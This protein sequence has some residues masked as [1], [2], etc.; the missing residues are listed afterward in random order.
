V[1]ALEFLILS[2][3]AAELPT[4]TFADAGVAAGVVA[5]A[6]APFQSV[7]RATRAP[8]LR[9]IAGSA[10]V[11]TEEDLERRELNDIHRVLAEVPGVYFREE[12]G[13]GLRPNIG[14]RG[15]SPDRSAKVTLLEDG[16]LL[17]PAPYSAPAAYYFPMITRMVG[18]EVFKGPAAIRFGP[19]T[20][21]GAVALSTR[22]VPTDSALRADVAVGSRNQARLHGVAALANAKWG[23]LAE[24]VWWRDSGFKSLDGG[25]DTGFERSE[26]MLKGRWTPDKPL[27]RQLEIKA[28]ASFEDSRETYL[29]L[30]DEDF[31]KQP[32]RRYSAS[33]LDRMV[34]QRYSLVAKWLAEPTAGM[35][36]S[37]NIY[38]HQFSR[39]WTRLDGF[40]EGPPLYELLSRPVQGGLDAQFL[41]I[42]R[43]TSDSASPDESLLIVDNGR[44]FISQG[45]QSELKWRLTTGLVSHELEASVRLHQ[46]EIQRD[47]RAQGYAMR[48]G[49]LVRDGSSAQQTALNR[50]ASRALSVHVGDALSFGR[51][52]LAPGA[53]LEVVESDFSDRLGGAAT[54][55]LQVVPLFGLGAVVNLFAGLNAFTGVHQGFS[56][57]TPG[58]D[59]QVRPERA[60][61]VEAGLRS[62]ARKRR[63]ELVGFF[64]EYS[65]ITGECTGSSGCAEDALNRQYNGGAARIVGLEALASTA[66][67]LPGG[68][69]F[70][71][72][73]TYTLTRA[74]FQSAFISA[75]PSWGNVAA[76]DSLPYVPTH[77]GAIRLRFDWQS[78]RLSLGAEASGAFG[79]EAQSSGMSPL[80]PLRVLVD[81]T[82]SFR[83][84]P[85]T[86]Y[87]QGTNLLNAE[88]LVARRPFGARP[89]APLA[90]QTGVRLD[91]P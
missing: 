45:I 11:L 27:L 9:R 68:L 18:L 75:N 29:G 41:S 20:I 80:V 14:L 44:Q 23:V 82:A 57:V 83:L 88:T 12:D 54:Q 81:A 89:L 5:D 73:V 24:A 70:I 62:V 91:W 37:T 47:H 40:R 10:T 16:V 71:P 25:G 55:G 43:G 7:V 8:D 63:F 42:L 33:A 79:E 32:N 86:F 13:L 30:A 56:P 48:S 76:G 53:R 3:A 31:Q 39:T 1:I 38:R 15:A 22:D 59:A 51:V 6:G 90:V 66:V 69:E 4:E 50:G 72:Q 67:S 26:Y 46:D 84:G 87:A 34:W 2:L 19:Q 35:T 64:S 61:H 17:G 36:L 21:G 60:T 49:A 58:Q 85:V 74:T 52:L 77:Q 28:T 65:N 78:V